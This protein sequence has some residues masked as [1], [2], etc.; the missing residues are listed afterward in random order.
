MSKIKT[1]NE[2]IEIIC[3]Q[4]CTVVRDII[5]KLEQQKIVVELEH[6]DD[7]QKQIVLTELKTV[8]S[9]YDKSDC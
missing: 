5:V 7:K 1:S 6:L 8:M 3:Q 2:C 4:G 9:V